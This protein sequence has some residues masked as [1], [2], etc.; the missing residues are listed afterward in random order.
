MNQ[1]QKIIEI[2]HDFETFKL[3][4]KEQG[5]YAHT[6]SYRPYV[7]RIKALLI[8]N[9][10]GQS[11]QFYC[12]PYATGDKPSRCRRQCYECKTEPKQ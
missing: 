5:V 1:D 11:E 4:D 9:V 2:L 6:S 7:E 8:H 3:T 10:V 12:S